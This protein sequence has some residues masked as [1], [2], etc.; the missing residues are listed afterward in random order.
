MLK[1]S[2]SSFPAI[3]VPSYHL[4]GCTRTI[5][6]TFVYIG[7]L[8][9]QVMRILNAS[10]GS[11]AV[12]GGMSVYSV[13]ETVDSSF[14]VRLGRCL[15]NHPGGNAL[16]LKINRIIS[17]KLAYAL[18]VFCSRV[19]FSLGIGSWENDT[20]PLVPGFHHSETSDPGEIWM[21]FV[22]S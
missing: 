11:Q 1:V 21:L 8:P 17:N 9:R 10:I 18:H 20:Q 6:H 2:S 14:R 13:A 12:V 22:G 3:S 16:D 5:A 19:Y 4:Y 7:Y 15:I